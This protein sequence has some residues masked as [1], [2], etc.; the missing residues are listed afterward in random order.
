MPYANLRIGRYSASGMT[1]H[2]TTVTKNRMPLFRD[3][4]P[5]R[6][7]VCQLK[8]LHDEGLAGHWFSVMGIAKYR[9]LAG[10]PS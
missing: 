3:L 9:R 8:A 4:R 5:A 6:I 1:Y 2:I 7:V 10:K